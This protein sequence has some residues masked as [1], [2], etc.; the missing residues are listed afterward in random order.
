MFKFSTFALDIW[1]IPFYEHYSKSELDVVV[2]IV[3]SNSQF[4]I[5][6]GKSP[7]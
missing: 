4:S 3:P 7:M 5:E 6:I 2:T 1:K